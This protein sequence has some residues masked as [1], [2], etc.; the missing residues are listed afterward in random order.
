MKLQDLFFIIAIITIIIF[1]GKGS[2]HIGIIS[3][4]LSGLLFLMG[5]LYTAQRLSWY[6]LG[7]LAIFIVRAVITKK[8]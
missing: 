8:S 5:N 3:F 4:L 7:F 6:A 2:W 1:K